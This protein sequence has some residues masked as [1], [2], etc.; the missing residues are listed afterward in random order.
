MVSLYSL[1][2]QRQ[3]LNSKSKRCGIK[4]VNIY[5][6]LSFEIYTSI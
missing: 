3:F 5:G 2:V 4:E 6:Q 1:G